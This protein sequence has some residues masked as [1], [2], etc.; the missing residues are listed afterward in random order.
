[1]RPN[2]FLQ[3]VMF[4][5]RMTMMEYDFFNAIWRVTGVPA[6]NF[7]ICLMVDA[8]TKLYPDALSRL[9]SAAVKDPEISGLCG[10][11]RIAN[12]KDS[13]VSI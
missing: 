1:M 4:D 11:T 13:W 6:D 9:I 10:E 5:E 8:D 12:K 7:E 3:K 2:L